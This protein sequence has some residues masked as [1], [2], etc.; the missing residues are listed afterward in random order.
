MPKSL[1][2]EAS[3][4][5]PERVKLFFES[6]CECVDGCSFGPPYA[7]LDSSF[8]SLQGEQR[9]RGKRGITTR[10]TVSKSLLGRGGPCPY[11][12]EGRQQW[13]RRAL[14]EWTPCFDRSSLLRVVEA[15]GFS[16]VLPSS[17]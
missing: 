8:Y 1:W 12:A 2:C 7:C 9:K 6:V 13:L 17:F 14:T 5:A 15:V 3:Y 4:R 16:G 10:D 11:E